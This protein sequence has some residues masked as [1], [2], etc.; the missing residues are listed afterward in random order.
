MYA[1]IIHKDNHNFPYFMSLGKLDKRH[2]YTLSAIYSHSNFVT[3]KHIDTQVLGND[4][5]VTYN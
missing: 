4:S 1:H 5:A 3:A 2:Y